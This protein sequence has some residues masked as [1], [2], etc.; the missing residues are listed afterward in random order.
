MTLLV[1]SSITTK[2]LHLP[3][4]AVLAACLWTAAPSFSQCNVSFTQAP[5]SPI[6][7]GSNPNN[8]GIGDFNSDGKLDLAIT[9]NSSNSVSVLLGS[10]SGS[11]TNGTSFPT[12]AHP[13]ES[14]P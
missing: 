10:G 2:R 3:M 12:G 5:N 14:K 7:V 13:V 6:A 4:A 11:F 8:T 9:N 1:T